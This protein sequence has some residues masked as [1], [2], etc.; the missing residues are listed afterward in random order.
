[1]RLLAGVAL[2]SGACRVAAGW[3]QAVACTGRRLLQ[4][5]C[6]QGSS[7]AA[8]AVGDGSRTGTPPSAHPPPASCRSAPCSRR[9]RCVGGGE[10]GDERRQVGELQRE[11]AVPRCAVRR[12]VPSAA[13]RCTAQRFAFPCVCCPPGTTIR[14]QQQQQQQRQPPVGHVGLL[15]HGHHRHARVNLGGQRDLDLQGRRG[16]GSWGTAR[17]AKQAAARAKHCSSGAVGPGSAGGGHRTSM[18]AACRRGRA[19][20][21]CDAHRAQPSHRRAQMPPGH[22]RARMQPLCS[23]GTA[24]ACLVLL[25]VHPHPHALLDV[26]RRN[27]R[28]RH[29]GRVGARGERYE[30]HRFGPL[31][32][33]A[34]A[35]PAPPPHTPAAA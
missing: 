28:E 33:D 22:Q 23:T 20:R 27:L 32:H 26:R 21:R 14:Q 4:G 3:Q 15:L 8:L 17:H 16:A 11:T 25:A 13:R 31:L 35:L 19:A 10:G 30:G 34:G 24:A 2:F 5:D 6:P 9:C 7:T 18:S 12:A 29:E 1:M